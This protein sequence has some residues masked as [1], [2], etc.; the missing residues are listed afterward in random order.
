MYASNPNGSPVFVTLNEIVP[1]PVPEVYEPLIL[2]ELFGS[3]FASYG[4]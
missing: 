1:T 4:I 2:Y 3:E